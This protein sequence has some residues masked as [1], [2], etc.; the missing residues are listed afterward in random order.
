[1]NGAEITPDRRRQ[2]AYETKL[3]LSRVLRALAQIS[4]LIIHTLSASQ[5]TDRRMSYFQNASEAVC[6]VD[7]LR[8]PVAV[9]RSRVEIVLSGE[10]VVEAAV[11][12]RLLLLVALD[13][14][15]Q[16]SAV[17]S[18]SQTLSQDLSPDM[19]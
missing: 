16:T 5:Q 17:H 10:N 14:V 6:E 7:R 12:I 1:M 4:C 9:I 11:V 15:A 13:G 18:S 3:M 8:Q 19:A 2:P